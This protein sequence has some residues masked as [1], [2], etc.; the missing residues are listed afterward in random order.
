MGTDISA[1]LMAGIRIQKNV[2]VKTIT[3]YDENTGKAYLKHI[4]TLHYVIGGKQMTYEEIDSEFSGDG[5]NNLT[6]F[7]E[8]E[9]DEYFVIGIDIADTGSNRS[10]TSQA[11]LPKTFE[12]VKAKME[13]AETLL[14]K[15]NVPKNEVLLCLISDISY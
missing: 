2:A 15:Y 12:E 10:N 9:S 11:I 14:E 13:L 4:D 5:E 8:Q 1:R 7:H 6:Y 3:K